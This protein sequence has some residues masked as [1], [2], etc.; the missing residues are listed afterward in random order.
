MD[1]FLAFIIYVTTHKRADEAL[2]E[3]EKRLHDFIHCS[4]EA[5][6]LFDSELN[7]LDANDPALEL[8]GQPREDALRKHMLEL[9]P[10][11]AETGRYDAYMRVLN[12]GTPFK[13]EEAVGPPGF[14]DL[15]VN[16]TAF[17]AG[18]GLGIIVADVTER[19][20]AEEVLQRA[21]EE[22]EGKVERCLEDGEH[23]GLTFRE[24]TVLHLLA[25]GNR[26]KE[27]AAVLGI[28]TLTASKHVSRILHKMNVHSR[29]AAGTRALREGL[30]D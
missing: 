19:K 25:D 21:R 29:T 26:D 6:Y 23:Y 12:T 22:L 20:Q 2:R 24:L 1:G 14:E 11:L 4:T 28:R 30:L 13:V 18:D 3:G 17:R 15:I 9:S 16:V 7:L 5:F 8:L 10:S 27:I